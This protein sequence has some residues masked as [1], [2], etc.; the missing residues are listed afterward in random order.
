MLW[1][2][3]SPPESHFKAMKTSPCQ[4]HSWGIQTHWVRRYAHHAYARSCSPPG[5][6]QLFH[7]FAQVCPRRAQAYTSVPCARHGSGFV[8]AVYAACTNVEWG[9]RIKHA[10]GV[11]RTCA[12]WWPKAYEG[13]RRASSGKGSVQ[14]SNAARLTPRRSRVQFP[15]RSSLCLRV[16]GI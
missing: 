5:V 1:R 10:N 2:T 12:R 6:T 11:H 7:N 14:S 9:G 3:S 16:Y 13:S 4:V 15:A 8:M